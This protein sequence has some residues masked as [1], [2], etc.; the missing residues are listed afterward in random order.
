MTDR[1]AGLLEHYSLSARVFHS[2]LVC[3]RQTY[4]GAHGYLHL[5]R[6]GPLTVRCA[7]H[8]DVHVDQ[9][10][11]LLYPRPANHVF[12]TDDNQAANLLCAA[13]DLGTTAGN[14]LAI[15][16]PPMLLIPLEKLPSLAAT[17]ELLFTEAL[18]D[19]CGRQAAIDRLCELLLI[20]LLRYLMDEQLAP[21]GL[22]AGLADPRLAKAI[23]AMHDAP[24]QAWTLDAL[25]TT[26]GMSRARFAAHF[27]ELIG[28]TPGH[29]LAEWR[30]NVACTL[31]RKG[32]PVT[33]VADEVGYGSPTALSRAFRVHTGES[34]REWQRKNR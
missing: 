3:G 11:L 21:S 2:G 4:D 34:P 27:H 29:F 8:P 7:A 30:V 5:I 6:R 12:I 15:A 31:L 33:V 1:L 23:A 9:P 16:L 32:K 22:L 19:Q 20:Q 17:L 26:A 24:R 10:S 28:T 18:A 25:A 13:V 14:P